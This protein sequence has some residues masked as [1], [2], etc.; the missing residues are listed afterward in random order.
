MSFIEAAY[1]ILNK[2]GSPLSASEITALGLKEGLITTKGKTPIATMSAIIYMDI[3]KKAALSRFTKPKKG[4]FGLRDWL[5]SKGPI[6]KTGSFKDAALKVLKFKNKLLNIQTI[7]E[8]ALKK[9][10]LTTTGKT[11]DASMGAQLYMDVKRLG[12]KSCFVQLG[13]NRFGLREW[14]LDVIK[15]EMEKQEKEETALSRKRSI[16]GE[17]INFGG[18][19]Y[20][21][22]NENGVIF[23]FSKIHDKLGINIEAI[24]PT[25][26]DAKGC[27][28]TLKG[29]E[30]VWI[31]FEYK[32][33]NFKVQKHDPK[34]CDIIVCWTHDWP[35]CPIE[36]IELKSVIA[37]LQGTI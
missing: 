33:S 21:P 1:Q 24:Q 22:L 8:I 36:V 5:E 2:T 23:L 16:V 30:D 3:K 19:I 35:D 37:K 12:D 27:R 20:G 28:K 10:F 4:K 32:S 13:K 15:T 6:F 11:P 17:P 14:G 26:P 25:Y 29:W 34:N 18:L 7:T 31:E 9:E